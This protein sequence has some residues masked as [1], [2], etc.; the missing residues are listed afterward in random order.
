MIRRRTRRLV[1]SAG[2]AAGGAAGGSL[3]RGL[4]GPPGSVSQDWRW[5]D[6]R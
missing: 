1:L 3:G 6:E 5:H 4:W 2:G